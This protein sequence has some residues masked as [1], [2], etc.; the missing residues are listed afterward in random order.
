MWANSSSCP[1]RMWVYVGTMSGSIRQL[2]KN[3]WLVRVDRG[4]DSLTGKRIQASKTV[5]GNRRDAERLLDELKFEIRH[6]SSSPSSLTLSAL[7][8]IWEKSPTRSG[9]KRSSVSLYNTRRRFVRHIEPAI[10]SRPISSLKS[11]EITLLLDAL[12]VRHGISPATAGRIKSELR[13]MINWA[14]KRGLVD[15][16]PMTNVEVPSVPLRPPVSLTCEE[17][18]G[19]LE[20]LSSDNPDLELLVTFAAT[21]GLRRSEIIALRWSHVD[22][23]RGTLNICEGVTKVPGSS[24]ETTET[25]TGPHGFATFPLHANLMAR[26]RQRRLLFEETLKNAEIAQCSDGYIF[27]KDLLAQVPLHPDTASRMLAKHRKKH[28]ELPYVCLQGLRRY[29]AS[30]LYGEGEDQ[31]IAAAILRDTPQTT[32]RYY[33]AANQQR[34]RRAVLGVYERIETQREAI[35]SQKTVRLPLYTSPSSSYAHLST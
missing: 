9:K 3:Y 25:K 30:D 20:I 22:F 6:Q 2:E 4:R 1:I 19:H 18:C 17:L 8:D 14:I 24:F 32:A 16:N 29:A 23:N 27:S 34:A 10:G 26:L 15:V 35:E 33:R 12:M 28:P 21:L 31:T 11:T 5:R 13:G 7:I